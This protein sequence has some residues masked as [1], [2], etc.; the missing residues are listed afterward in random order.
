MREETALPCT[1]ELAEE[2]LSWAPAFLHG[3]QR[4]APSN[5]F[6]SKDGHP[7]IL[8]FPFLLPYSGV[9]YVCVLLSGGICH[10][11]KD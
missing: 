1:R 9:S 6:L 10:P 3:L 5:L 7:C 8:G 4:T 2:A 11:F